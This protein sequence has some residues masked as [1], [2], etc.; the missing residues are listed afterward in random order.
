M[1]QLWKT[2][3]LRYDNL[4]T[5]SSF[6]YPPETSQSRDS[7]RDSRYAIL[8]INIIHPIR[9]SQI[10]ISRFLNSDRPGPKTLVLIS[11]TSAQDTSIATPLYDASKHAISG[12]VRSL[13]DIDTAGIRIVAVAP[14][15]I[16]TP[17]YTENPDKLAMI[18]SVSDVWV[19][20]QEVA[21]VMVALIERDTMSSTIG[22]YDPSRH[23]I[24]ITSGT[25]LEVTKARVRAVTAYNDPGPSGPGAL[26]SNMTIS[27]D[28]VK[29][30]LN[31]G[32]GR[33]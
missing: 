3:S 12:F 19:E 13:K 27:E 31:K 24:T 4:Q 11:S 26:A 17:L 2:N 1:E 9:T 29:A 16:K 6:W 33:T 32:W 18:N 15:I 5:W 30:L 8:D 10:A 21:E 14:G 25:I 7:V 22:N 28:A 23:D 20:P